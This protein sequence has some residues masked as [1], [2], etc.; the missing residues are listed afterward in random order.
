MAENVERPDAV[1]NRKDREAIRRLTFAMSPEVHDQLRLIAVMER[2]TLQGLLMEGME[3]MV[4]KRRALGVLP[5][6]PARPPV[7]EMAAR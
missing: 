4:E 2:A 1:L 3:L 7:P 6:M 5:A